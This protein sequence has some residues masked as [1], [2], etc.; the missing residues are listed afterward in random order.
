MIYQVFSIYDSATQAYMRPFNA[1]SEGQALRMWEDLIDDPQA[2]IGK[3]PEDYSLY[4]VATFDDNKGQHHPNDP[5]CISRAHEVVARK[6]A[7]YIQQ[8][9]QHAEGNNN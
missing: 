9:H 4:H 6:K 1:Q 8:V 5:R 2:D 3:H 7:E